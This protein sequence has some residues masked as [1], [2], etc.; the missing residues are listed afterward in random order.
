MLAPRERSLPFRPAGLIL[1]SPEV[2]LHLREPSIKENAPHD[3][4]PW[5]IPTA[6]YLHGEDPSR[7][8]FDHHA[9]D[10][11]G[12]PPTF[13]SWGEAEMF[14][15][16]IRMFVERLETSRVVH[17]GHESP[18]MFHVFPILMPWADESRHVYREV[19]RFVRGILAGAPALPP[20]AIS[21]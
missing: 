19:A 2:D 16:A 8:Y 5:N 14:R 11:S 12:F 17:Q 15:D 1:F 7:R 10:L 9:A 4:L 3:I 20:G 6:V 18:G 13:V 21:G